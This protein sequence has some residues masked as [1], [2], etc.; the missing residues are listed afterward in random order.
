MSAEIVCVGQ[1]VADVVVH[2]VAGLPPTG[3]AALVKGIELKTGGC[4]CNTAVL[5]RKLGQPAALLGKLGRDAFGDFLAGRLQ[6]AGLDLGGIVRDASTLTSSVI[7][8]IGTSGERSFLYCPGANEQLTLDDIAW[9]AIERS[10][11]VHVGGIMKLDSL[12]IAEL[13]RRAKA[14]GK[15]TSLDTDWDPTGRWFDTIEPFLPYTDLFLPSLDEARLI[16]GLEAPSEIARFFLDRG[17]KVVALKLGEQGCY[18]R[19][20]D[21]ECRLPAY[22]VDVV[23]TTGAGDAFVAG[24]LAGWRMGWPLEKCGLLGNAC[25]GLC[26]TRI[27]TTD[28]VASLKECV[29]FMESA[30][31]AAK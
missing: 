12:D 15:T 16:A 3:S 4:G 17:P 5:L 31:P 6:T 18:I 19:T 23:D 8:L 29:S 28:G 1:I 2:P 10:R 21:R 30:A 14:L 11:M 27:G 20:A 13:L 25:G 7:V 24:F 22:G 9:Q 26:V